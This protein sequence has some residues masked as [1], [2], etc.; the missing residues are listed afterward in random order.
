MKI[1]VE[2]SDDTAADLAA[3]R[4]R[5]PSCAEFAVQDALV[6]FLRAELC[7]RR[8][9]RVATTKRPW[10]KKGDLPVNSPEPD[11]PIYVPSEPGQMA[12]CEFCGKADVK[13]RGLS[14]HRATC[15]KN[16]NRKGRITAEVGC[17]NGQR[18]EHPMKECEG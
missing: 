1:T 6:E 5:Y 18:H 9:H 16:P 10:R 12:H 4:K 8:L 15:P 7:D 3:Y 14:T 13:A 2:I 11:K 17:A